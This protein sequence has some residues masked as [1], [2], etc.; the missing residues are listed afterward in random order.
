M[1]QLI[2]IF[3]NMKKYRVLSLICFC[4]LSVSLHAQNYTAIA[5]NDLIDE[6]T[7][8]KAKGATYGEI[9][10][11]PY[12][13]EEFQNGEVYYQKKFKITPIL[14]RYNLYTDQIEY[15]E[16]DVIMTFANPDRIDK[17]AIVD[18]V[19]V[20]VNNEYQKKVS[21]FARMWNEQFPTVITKMKVEFLEKEETKG[22]E[23][24]KPDRFKRT[25]DIH[26]LMKSEDEIE[27]ISSVK[28]LIKSLGNHESEL[29]AFAKKEKISANDPEEL[30]RL[31]E[32]YHG[33]D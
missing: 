9:Q 21:G 11:S 2:F 18:D 27:K 25:Y 22:Y 32:F 15:K 12:L 1:H 14:L 20:F 8:N 10:G 28:K 30:A 16:K 19:F 6:L 17:V 26:Y 7:W 4:F 31:L 24:S 23:E 33:L 13:N 3:C 29:S 5:L